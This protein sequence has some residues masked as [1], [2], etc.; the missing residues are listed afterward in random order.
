MMKPIGVEVDFEAKAGYVSYSDSDVA[1]TREVWEEGIVA[2]DL[3]AEGGIVG[4]EM[5]GLD[6]ETI[7]HARRYAENHD[8]VFPAMLDLAAS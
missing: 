5:L 7:S 4:I 8:L 3:D 6:S 1:E 2:A